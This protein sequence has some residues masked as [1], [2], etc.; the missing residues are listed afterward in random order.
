MEITAKM[1]A[2]LI[3]ASAGQISDIAVIEPRR[4]RNEKPLPSAALLIFTAQDV[5]LVLSTLPSPPEQPRRVY[6][7]DIYTGL[8]QGRE[9]AVVGPSLGA[10]QTI[11]ILEKLIALGVNKILA[12][13]WCGSLQSQVKIGDVVLPTGAISEEGT[14]THYPIGVPQPG[15][16][17]GLMGVI[18][19]ALK[20]SDLN[21]HEGYVWTTDAPYRETANKIL[22]YQREGVLAVE[23]EVS[24]MFTVACFRCIRLAAALIVS[25][26]L[27]S[28][29]WMHGFRDVNFQLARQKMIDVVLRVLPEI[30]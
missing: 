17:Q 23:M 30:A 18:K 8:L 5:Q 27:H 16:D 13:G 25:D 7:A 26:D 3:Q 4:G 19:E 9:I 22:T 20:T 29:K 14:S 28:L 1:T 12:L 11:M 15:P 21:M 6:L 2:P 24:A 10:P